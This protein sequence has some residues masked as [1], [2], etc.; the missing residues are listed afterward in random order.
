MN[1]GRNLFILILVCGLVVTHAMAQQNTV[2]NTSSAHQKLVDR[3]L[4]GIT[5]D[6]PNK[7]G[8]PAVAEAMMHRNQLSPREEESLAKVLTRPATQKSITAGSF[9]IHYDTVGMNAPAMLDS[10]HTRIEGTA[11]RYADSVAAIVNYALRFERDSLGYPVPPSDNGTGGGPEYDIYIQE[12]SS[13]YGSTTP[14]SPINNKP[15]GGT[16]TSY[17][18]I[19]NDFMFVSPDS[20]KGLPALRVT[21]A[22]ELHHA[23][24]MGNY[25][26]WSGEIYFYEMTSV[27]MEDAV[28]TQVNDYYQYLRSSQGQFQRSEASFTSN[29][30][31][32]YSRGI[33]C[34]YLAKKYGRESIKRCWEEIRSARPFLAIDAALSSAPFSVSLR[35]AFIEWNIWNYYTAGRSESVHFYPEGRYYPLMTPTRIDFTPP[36]RTVSNIVYPFG[37]RYYEVTSSRQNLSLI[38]LNVN[39]TLAQSDN[40]NAQSFSLLLNTTKVDDSYKPTSAQIFVKTDVADPTNWYLKDLMGAVASELPFPNPFYVDG[41]SILQFPLLSSFQISGSLTIFS[42]SMD[43]I[44]AENQA[45]SFLSQLGTHVLKWN[46]RNMDNKVVGSGVYIY[47]IVTPTQTIKGKIAVLRK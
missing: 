29:N 38:V 21:L 33:W 5:T 13:L 24:Q 1:A 44:Y 14:E 36:S 10:S 3:W 32:M 28:F 39:S 26:F 7:C 31:I 8:L 4:G 35:N 9:R 47:V 22:H 43:L 20:N 46:G 16:F 6:V 18:L 12:L 25:G 27:W 11:D 19:D 45:S 37:S 30:F 34:H 40:A 15:A 17:I 23:I 2:S 42:T 41:Q